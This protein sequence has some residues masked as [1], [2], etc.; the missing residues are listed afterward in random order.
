MNRKHAAQLIVAAGV[1]FA[2]YIMIQFHRKRD[3]AKAQ[4][5]K[6]LGDSSARPFGYSLGDNVKIH[7]VSISPGILQDK[8]QTY[9]L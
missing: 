5:V 4:A 3:G 6:A 9:L 8:L 2:A 7:G 1:G